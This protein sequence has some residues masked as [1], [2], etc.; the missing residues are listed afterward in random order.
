[1]HRRALLWTAGSLAVAALAGM[2]AV[3]S[4]NANRRQPQ[5]AQ[6][7]ISDVQIDS[8]SPADKES[9]CQY[10]LRA[11]AG[12]LAVYLP[13]EEEPQMVFDTPVRV[14]PEFDQRQLEEGI[15]VKDYESLVR[16]IEDFVS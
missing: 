6:R 15:P 10:I 1:M 3:Y 7:P 12:R 4:Y 2:L 11:D 5:S 8:D 9:D 14:L 13:G 16:M